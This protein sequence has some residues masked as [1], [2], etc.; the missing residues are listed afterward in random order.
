MTG[1]RRKETNEETEEQN[2]QKLTDEKKFAGI[3][4]NQTSLTVRQALPTFHRLA[5]NNRLQRI[6]AVHFRRNGTRQH[7]FDVAVTIINGAHQI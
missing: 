5:L 2:R 6:E 3:R 4:Q 1:E 7:S